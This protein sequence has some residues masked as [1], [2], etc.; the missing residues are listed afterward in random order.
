MVV[1]DDGLTG[2]ILTLPQT[3][4]QKRKKNSRKVKYMKQ[5]QDSVEFC[6]MFISFFGKFN[7]N[8]CFGLLMQIICVNSFKKSN[9]FKKKPE[10]IILVRL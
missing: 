7:Q 8:L 2:M 6:F 9:F 3:R 5:S 4:Q 10:E 1:H